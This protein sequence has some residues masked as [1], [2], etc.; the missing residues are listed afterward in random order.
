MSEGAACSTFTLDIRQR[1]APPRRVEAAAP[2]HPRLSVPAASVPP[3]R[4]DLAHSFAHQRRSASVESDLDL[5]SPPLR[6]RPDPS[7][8]STKLYLLKRYSK[9]YFISSYTEAHHNMYTGI[10][11]G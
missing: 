11:I 8:P 6:R 3:P 2:A 7:P 4:R 5:V 1:F 10:G 9:Y